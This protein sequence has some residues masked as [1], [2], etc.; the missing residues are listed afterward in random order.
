MFIDQKSQSH[1]LLLSGQLLQR[2]MLCAFCKQL[3]IRLLLCLCNL[4]VA[5]HQQIVAVRSVHGFQ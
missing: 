3:L 2:D 4:A 1:K 5:V